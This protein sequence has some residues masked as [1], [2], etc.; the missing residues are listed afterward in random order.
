MPEV[1]SRAPVP[2][3]ALARL[4]ARMTGRE[5]ALPTQSPA[6]RLGD[7]LQWQQ[8]V[9]LS[10]ALDDDPDADAP[11]AADGHGVAS[12]GRALTA[13]AGSPGAA[14]D[15]DEDLAAEC[16]RLRAA[17]EDAIADDARDWTLPLRPRA[18]EDGT[19][20]A[21]GAAAVLRHCQGLQRDLQSASGRL[22]GELRER[23]ALRPGGAARLAA[24]DAV[25][26]G[27]LAPREHALLV[28]AVPTL[29]ARFEQLHA[30]HGEG[31]TQAAAGAW[32]ASFRSEARQVLLA[33]LD[34]RFQPIEALLAALHCPR[35]DA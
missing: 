13:D 7:W 30:R 21:A 11:P 26:E 28:P 3:A 10:R 35:P 5:A 29:V 20:A 15:G 17:L 6:D 19:G 33:E 9:L 24:V 4:L 12:P 2:G 8:A 31:G 22:R 14:G 32:R 34:L 1:R 27:L 23:L 25:M 18:G 16:R